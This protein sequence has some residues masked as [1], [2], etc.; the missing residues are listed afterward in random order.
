VV[1]RLKQIVLLVFAFLFLLSTC[2]HTETPV[3]AQT[4]NNPYELVVA[5]IVEPDTVDPAWAYDTAS[6]ELIFN[7]YETLVFYNRESVDEFVPMLATDWWISE[8]CLTY[9]FKIR[10]GVKFHNGEIL[11]TEDIEYSFERAMVHDAL[12]SPACMLY[13]ALLGCRHANLSDPDWHVK[14]ENAVQHNDTHAWFQLVEP[15]A[16][17]LQILCQSW[18]SIANKKFCVEHG[19]WPANETAGKWFWPGGDWTRYYRPEN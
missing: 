1:E 5:A 2:L 17:F 8:D 3:S 13:E 12:T 6:S 16:P 19:D 14:I 11:T 15:Y 4:V 7:V 9:T 10:E 18:S